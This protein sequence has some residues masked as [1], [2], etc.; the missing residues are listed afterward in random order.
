MLVSVLN[1]YFRDVKHFV[2]LAMKILFYTVPIV[3]PLQPGAEGQRG[4][5]RGTSRSARSTS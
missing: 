4:R 2:S 5:R 1:V 3:Y